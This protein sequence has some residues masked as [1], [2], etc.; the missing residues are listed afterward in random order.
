VNI[1]VTSYCRL[2]VQAHV[3]ML[4]LQFNSQN[5]IDMLYLS[6]NALTG[7]IPSEFGLLT[8]LCEYYCHFLLPPFVQAHVLMLV[9]QFNSQNT[10]DT[11]DLYNNNFT[12]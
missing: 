7:T 9:L 8:N 11:L 2:F 5:T 6:D 12:G 10:I 3:L 1:A 4:V